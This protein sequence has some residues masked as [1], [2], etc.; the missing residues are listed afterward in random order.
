MNNNDKFTRVFNERVRSLIEDHYCKRVDTRL[1]HLWFVRLHH[2]SNGN[3]VKLCGYPQSGI[4]TQWTNHI[5]THR[6]VIE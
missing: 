4:I 1:P 5:E 3:D 6:E 2:M